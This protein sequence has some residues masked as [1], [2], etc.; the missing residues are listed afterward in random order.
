[1][2]QYSF[3]WADMLIR[4]C[5][6]QA[7][8]TKEGEILDHCVGGYARDVAEGKKAIFFI[9]KKTE[10][11]KPWYTLELNEKELRVVQNRGKKN[12][13]RTEAVRRFE[14][15]WLGWL[16]AGAMR[17]AQGEPIVPDNKKKGKK[18]A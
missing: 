16:K 17:D 11:N 12:C 13:E 10:P 6:T 1:M 18:T 5:R 14:E 2:K 15:V 3:E 4:P 7:E 8:L 9:R